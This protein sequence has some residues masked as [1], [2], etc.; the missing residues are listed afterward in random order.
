MK[1]FHEVRSYDSNFMMWHSAYRNI[2]FLAHW[3]NELELI[4]IREGTCLITVNDDTFPAQAGS[5]VL[6]SSGDIHYCDEAAPQNALEFLIFDPGLLDAQYLDVHAPQTYLC[7]E[8][9][10][11]LGMSDALEALFQR[12]PMELHTRRPYYQEIATALLREF[13]YRLKRIIPEQSHPQNRRG[14]LM[15]SF[16]TLLRYL[17]A[18]YTEPLSLESAANRLGYTPS[19]FSKTFKKLAGINFVT[20]LS[21]IRVEQACARLKKGDER[22]VDIAQ[23]CGFN[24]LRTFN[25]TF[26]EITGYTPTQFKNLPNGDSYMLTYYKRRST[27]QTLAVWDSP[28]VISHFT[29]PLGK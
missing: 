29:P 5:L 14:G 11:A 12:V 22:M 25:R 28:T 13:W 21:M 6:C 20:Y 17:D 18:H 19:H 27:E 2:S 10:E 8:Q 3:H 15:E 26:K 24:N 4:Y 16:H 23:S 7:A 1:A 9:L